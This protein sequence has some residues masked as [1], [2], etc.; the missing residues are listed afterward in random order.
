MLADLGFNPYTSILFTRE[1]NLREDRALVEAMIRASLQGW[2]KYLSAPSATNLRIQTLNPAMDLDALEY[3]S[4][5]IAPL[6]ESSDTRLHGFGVMTHE[7][8]QTLI[9]QM[10]ACKQLAA[11]AVKASEAFRSDAQSDSAMQSAP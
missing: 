11:G 9:D 6:A 3:G 1:K 5:T 8:W 7:R 10:V 4:R 2:K